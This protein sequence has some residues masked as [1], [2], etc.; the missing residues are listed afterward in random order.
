MAKE[1]AP[2]KGPGTWIFKEIPRDLMQRTK[3]GAAIQG[4]GSVRSL[5]IELVEKHLEELEKK[6]LLPKGK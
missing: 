1:K 5:I 4:K 6:G 3:A 2:Q